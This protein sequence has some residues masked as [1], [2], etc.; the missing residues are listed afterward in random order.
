ME[1][2][3]ADE[4]TLLEN[5]GRRIK[6]H[7]APSVQVGMGKGRSGLSMKLHA[8]PHALRLLPPNLHA[9]AKLCRCMPTWLADQATEKA[10][11]SLKSIPL[12]QLVI[13][14]LAEAAPV[15]LG[16]VDLAP[17][18]VPNPEAVFDDVDF[19]APLSEADLVADLSG[20]LEVNDLLHC[21]HNATQESM[22]GY[23]DVI[24]QAK[25]V[26]DFVRKK[27]SK[28]RLI[29]TSAC[30]PRASTRSALARWHLA[31]PTSWL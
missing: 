30:S 10:I 2:R 14:T 7:T 24:Y 12:L 27:E 13:G 6:R 4:A 9:L 29:E 1:A 17:A 26:A 5:I 25:K 3:L 18:D 23:Q 19:A 21:L 16:E 28:D 8:L 11:A 22:P 15:E 20:S 31:S